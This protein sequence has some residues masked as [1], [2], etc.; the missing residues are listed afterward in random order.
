MKTFFL[1]KSEYKVLTFDWKF[2]QQTTID[3]HWENK[4]QMTI[5]LP[6]PVNGKLI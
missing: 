3:L 1:K 6:R 2:L 5:A 4:L